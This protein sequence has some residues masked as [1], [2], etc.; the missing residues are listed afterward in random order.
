[1]SI[2]KTKFV[3]CYGIKSLA[4]DFDFSGYGSK[5]FAIYAPN[6]LM[7]TSF[8]RT[9][10]AVSEGKEPKEERFNRPTTFEASIDGE[11]L[12]KENIYILKSEIDINSDDESVSNLL[13]N[14]E[15]KTKY[16]ALIDSIKKTKISSAMISKLQKASGVKQKDIEHT[17][18]NDFETSNLIEALL[19]AKRIEATFD[20]DI[21]IYSEVFDPKAI[22]ILDSREFIL[23]AK[24][25]VQRYDEVFEKSGGLYLKGVFNPNKAAASC[26]SL[27]KTCFL[28][29]GIRLK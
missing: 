1:M 8:T 7:K 19:E 3:N 22:E 11:Q 28:K 21:V 10:L 25:F 12:S 15:S 14:R 4:Y 16:D 20:S 13:I 9:F 18:M 6:G 27:E 29:L 2:L 17:L 5:A 26:S 24:E 23:K